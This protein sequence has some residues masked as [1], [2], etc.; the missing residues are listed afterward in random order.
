MAREQCLINNNYSHLYNYQRESFCVCV[1]IIIPVT[2]SKATLHDLVE[3][4]CG[5]CQPKQPAPTPRLATL[6]VVVGV[7]VVAVVVVIVAVVVVAFL[8]M[9]GEVQ[10]ILQL[11]EQQ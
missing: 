2:P 4:E 8:S 10:L 6:L 11:N 9:L 1:F 7:T 3:D 5:H